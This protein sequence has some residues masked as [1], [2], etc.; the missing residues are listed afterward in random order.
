M[1]Y[2]LLWGTVA[3]CF[4]LLGFAVGLEWCFNGLRPS[5]QGPEVWAL[6][7]ELVCT[8]AAMH[9]QGLRVRGPY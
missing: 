9:P 6:V 1:D 5:S 2:G 3:C 7:V 4:G 8:G